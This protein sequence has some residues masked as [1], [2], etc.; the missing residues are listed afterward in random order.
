MEKNNREKMV[1]I[2]LN[3]N[4]PT[5]DTYSLGD[6]EEGMGAHLFKI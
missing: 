4:C 3:N 2:H 6:S 1:F 5:Y